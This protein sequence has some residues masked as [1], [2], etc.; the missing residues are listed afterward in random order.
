MPK[1]SINELHFHLDETS[2]ILEPKIAMDE[3]NAS[4]VKK[5]FKQRLENPPVCHLA[6]IS[7]KLTNEKLRINLPP[8]IPSRP[9]KIKFI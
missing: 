5:L 3:K 4:F 8:N 6:K 9:R 1:Y 2:I 7:A